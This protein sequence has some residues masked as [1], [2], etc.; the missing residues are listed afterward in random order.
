MVVAA[1]ASAHH[2]CEGIYVKTVCVQAG[3]TD[4]LVPCVHCT[5]KSGDP[6]SYAMDLANEEVLWAA[7]LQEQDWKSFLHGFS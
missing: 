5:Q 4:V 2:E 7:E 1:A 3:G 6:V